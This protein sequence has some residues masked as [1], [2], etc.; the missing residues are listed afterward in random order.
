MQN[1]PARMNPKSDS[2]MM[3]GEIVSEQIEPLQRFSLPWICTPD[4]TAAIL[5]EAKAEE[6]LRRTYF[7]LIDFRNSPAGRQVCI[8][9]T[10]LTVWQVVMVACS[11]GMSADQTAHHLECPLAHVQTALDYAAAFPAEIEAA[12]TANRALGFEDMHGKAPHVWVGQFR[13]HGQFSVN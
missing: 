1:K 8:Q 11:Y 10:S 3:S 7:A 4:K 9:G 13:V 5:P 6:E 12:L 2:R